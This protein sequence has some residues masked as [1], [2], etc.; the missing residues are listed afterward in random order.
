VITRLFFTAILLAAAA[1]P[2]PPN[3][4]WVVLDACRADRL[5][6]YGYE[7]DT[8]PFLNRFAAEGAV[9]LDHRSQAGYTVHSLPSYMTGKLFP[10]QC[11]SFLSP[12]ELWRTAPAGEQLAPEIFR[13]NGYATAVVSACPWIAPGGRLTEAFDHAAC[14]PPGGGQVYAPL[15]S[16]TE[17]AMA[18]L[19]TVEDAP[20]FLYVHAMD[21]HFPHRLRAGFDTW[22]PGEPRPGLTEGNASA[23]PF[24]AM[25]QV[26]LS[27]LY[28]GS[29]HYADLLL[30]NLFS[31][32]HFR[33]HL[34]N[35][36]VVVGA[37][38]GDVLGE[39]GYTLQ[40][41]PH[42]T[43]DEVYH[44]PLIV[45]G[46]GVKAGVRHADQ[47]A[48][49]D[50]LPTLIDLVGLET[51]AVME[52]RSLAPVLQGEGDSSDQ[53][54]TYARHYAADDFRVIVEGPDWKYVAG[55]GQTSPL[56]FRGPDP[57]AGRH[58]LDPVPDKTAETLAKAWETVVAP[59][60]ELYENLPLTDA[61]PFSIQLAAGT[62]SPPEAFSMQANPDDG[63]WAIG[64]DGG[65]S[66]GPGEHPAPLT[67]RF[68]VPNAT[69]VL[70][71]SSLGTLPLPEV[72]VGEARPVAEESTKGP[73]AL[74]VYAVDHETITL[75]LRSDNG[76]AGA[77]ILYFDPLGSTPETVPGGAA[78]QREQLRALGYL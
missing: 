70:R 16:L 52:G 29:L 35:T 39:D 26:Q 69:Y 72:T 38:H 40:H 6:P 22:V 50:I 10:A 61:A 9:F 4:V 54:L 15:N 77:G 18:W 1:S 19:K 42:V 73:D 28:D 58:A 75:T 8:T 53:R 34:E 7:R 11:L 68:R 36:I 65:V 20:F 41:P 32:L 64:I 45:R 23:A 57:I 37:D 14:V 48:N 30:R 46:P 33:G 17:A 49:L 24:D 66:C 21:T 13:A 5:S 25:D 60:W 51:E 71:L 55:P 78:S 2:A 62:A 43:A 27:G 31:A 56:W 67:L 3:V 74:G 59:R 44:V 76:A 12:F 63:R 47:T